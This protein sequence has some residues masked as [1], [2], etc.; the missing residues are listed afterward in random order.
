MESLM[1]I[2]GMGGGLAPSGT[3]ISFVEDTHI[4]EARQR[5]L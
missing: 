5:G 3:P 2:R 1:M 4:P